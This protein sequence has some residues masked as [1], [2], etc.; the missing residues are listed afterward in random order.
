MSP[1]LD[2]EERGKVALVATALLLYK[3][4]AVDS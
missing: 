3:P 4:A 2:E 1:A